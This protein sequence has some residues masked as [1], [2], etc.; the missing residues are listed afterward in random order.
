MSK[1]TRQQKKEEE[2]RIVAEMESAMQE[3]RE[4]QDPPTAGQAEEQSVR[5]RYGKDPTP[6]K[7]H[8][9]RC[10]TLMENGVCPTCGFRVYVPMDEKKVKKIRYI[11]AGVCI[12][13]FLA[14]FLVMQLKG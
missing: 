9:K 6:E 2:R 3:Q 8:C 4:T 1:L 14:I 13:V 10:K 7:L 12:V 5:G 11:V